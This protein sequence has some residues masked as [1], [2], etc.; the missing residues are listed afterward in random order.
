V[1]GPVQTACYGAEEILIE[2]QQVLRYLGMGGRTPDPETAR[3]VAQCIEEFRSVASYRLCWADAHIAVTQQGVDFGAFYASSASLAQHLK[4]CKQAIL[5]AATTG[6]AAEQ[7]RKRAEVASP[8]KALVLDAVGTAAAEALC[9]RFCADRAKAS[10]GQQLRPRFSPGYGDLPLQIQG[11]FLA[12]VDAPR[13][14]GVCVS[15]SGLLVPRKSVTAI[16][17]L[18][19]EPVERHKKGCTSCN[20]AE[21]CPYRAK[22]AHCK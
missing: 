14:V 6:L 7:Q 4:E 18:S 1:T 11:D 10:A 2:P 22:G 16:I 5:F 19:K 3:L 9:D 20:A 12:A 13:R 15:E 8:A 17:G 21:T